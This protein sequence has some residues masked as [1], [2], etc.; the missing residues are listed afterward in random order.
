MFN[1]S[2]I[3][4][5]LL[6]AKWFIAVFLLMA[7]TLV[8][9]NPVTLVLANS[10]PQ[11]APAALVANAPELSNY[12]LVYQ[13]DLPNS[14]T[15]NSAGVNYNVDLSGSVATGSFDRVAYY[16]QLDSNWVEVSFDAAG[17]TNDAAK[18]GIP[19]TVSG[20]FFQQN[21]S[22]MNVSSNVAGIVT[23]TGLTGGNIEFWP[24]SYSASNDNGVPN[25]FGGIYDFGDGGAST[26]AGYGSM[27][28]HN[29]YVTP[30]TGQTIIA[31]NHWGSVGGNS[32]LGIGNQT[33]SQKDWT[34]ANNAG[35][36][37]T[38]SLYVLVHAL[39]DFGDA[40]AQYPVTLANNGAYHVTDQLCYLG[41]L[42]DYEP[43]GQP[44]A[45]ANGD[46]LNNLD[47]E[48][49]IAFT[50]P[51][52]PGQSA[53][54]NVTSVVPPTTGGYLN[55]W[56]DFNIDGDW[57]DPGEQIMTNQVL[58]GVLQNLTFSVPVDAKPGIT[59]ARFRANLGGG[60]G[61]A[62]PASNG[63]VEDY[64]VTIT[65]V[66][67]V[68]GE[69]IGVNKLALLAPWLVLIFALMVGAT[70]LVMSRRKES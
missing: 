40:P 45:G 62:G 30:T 9:S 32:D 23:G 19:N 70:I 49:G 47:D 41:N 53:S 24:S 34:F 39:C 21:V 55:A 7:L 64:Q 18:I 48:D 5:S 63:E 14:A 54:C 8:L 33:V 15:Y 60:L 16:L 11:L 46:D 51:L 44:S 6:K 59:Y 29:H 68:G 36:Y 22:N 17:F 4:L 27:Q 31:Y 58:T 28:I 56:I 10:T 20:E 61:P 42:K 37:A 26:A 2:K 12:W 1:K 57:D 52:I 25:A 67:S 66:L 3:A 13:K 50:T 38:K 65:Q 35:S 43:D 69:V